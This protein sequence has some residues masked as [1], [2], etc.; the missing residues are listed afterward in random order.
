MTTQKELQKVTERKEKD[1]RFA[2]YGVPGQEM[3]ERRRDM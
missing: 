3:E 1:S 2:F